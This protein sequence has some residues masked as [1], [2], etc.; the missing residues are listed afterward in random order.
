VTPASPTPGSGSASGSGGRAS[1][2]GYAGRTIPNILAVA[3]REFG[4]RAR[5]RAFRWS[6]IILVVAGV[7]L[8][9]TP[10][11]L[12]YF[13]RDSTGDRVDVFLGDMEPPAFDVTVALG[14]ILNTSVG[15]AVPAP[16]QGEPPP[17]FVVV[18]STDLDAS[19]ACVVAG[20]VV[21]V[22]A[23]GRAPGGDLKFDLY[24]GD[25]SPISRRNALLRQAAV[26]VT[27]QDR[28]TRAGVPP[29]DQATL[30]SPPEFVVLPAD[31]AA[32]PT[33]A[34][35]PNAITTSFFVGFGLSIAIFMAII[36][37][38]Q[39][40]AFSVAEEKSTRVMEIVLAAATPFQLLAGKVVGVGALALLQYVIVAVPSILAVVFQGQI[41][42]MLLGRAPADAM[43]AG[44]SISMLLAFGGML[45]LGFALYASL[46]AGV[47]S[48]V[49]RQ[50][51]VNSI[52]APLTFVSVGGYLVA[53]YVGTG[54]LPI[55][56]PIVVALS[57]VPLFSPYL[58]LTRYGLDTASALEVLVAMAL[59]L[60]AI[61]VALWLAARL[62]RAGVLLYGQPPTPRTLW[63]AL[64]AG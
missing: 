33:D 30:F 23:L 55:D 32:E 46:Y 52:I 44:L 6:T 60:L 4:Y 35:D 2:S 16:G 27:I 10:T 34:R 57:F 11:I 59:L 43:P 12:A 18:Q 37:Y 54:V 7:A 56:A 45:V 17:R 38:G 63:R 3:R 1:R 22:L 29:V 41:S 9:S 36:L 47:A 61:P 40:I 13:D 15:P 5:S 58:M 19:R 48:L 31:P 53:S 62:Y 28:L 64:R 50:E 26:A 21:A 42:A 20:D 39:W 14:A 24:T 25:S 51:D 49:S 8:A